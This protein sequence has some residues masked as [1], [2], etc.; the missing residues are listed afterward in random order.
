MTPSTLPDLDL[1]R[2]RRFCGARVPER[3]RH[4]VRLEIEVAGST[5]TIVEFRAPWS[6]ELGPEWSK[7]EI[8]RL[9]YSPTHRHW[10]LF[11][12]NPRRGWRH[13]AGIGPTPTVE[14]LLG[15]IGSDTTGAFWG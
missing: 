1:F 3:A 12:P 14:A 11:A 5:V 15:E 4:Q 10:A 2:I 7:T 13:Y 6:R 8:A 9:Q